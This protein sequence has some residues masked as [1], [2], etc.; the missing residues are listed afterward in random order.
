MEKPPQNEM[1]STWVEEKKFGLVT[2]SSN[3]LAIF[4]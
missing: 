4:F 1:F 3:A 2:D